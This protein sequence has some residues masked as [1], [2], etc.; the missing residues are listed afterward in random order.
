MVSRSSGL[1]ARQVTRWPWSRDDILRRTLLDAAEPLNGAL[2]GGV[3]T[4]SSLWTTQGQVGTSS[5]M[6]PEPERY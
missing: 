1:W 5:G 4:L 3:A 2:R 6:E